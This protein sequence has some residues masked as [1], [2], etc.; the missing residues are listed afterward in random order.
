MDGISNSGASSRRVSTSKSV[1]AVQCL[2]FTLVPY[3]LK[4]LFTRY[5]DRT[6]DSNHRSHDCTLSSYSLLSTSQFLY[7]SSDKPFPTTYA[8]ANITIPPTENSNTT[9]SQL[10]HVIDTTLQN[11]PQASRCASTHTTTAAAAAYYS[12]KL[13]PGFEFCEY[14]S[15]NYRCGC[16]IQD[17]KTACGKKCPPV[18]TKASSPKRQCPNCLCRE[19]EA[20]AE[21]KAQFAAW[22]GFV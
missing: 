11:L 19:R 13:A 15:Y 12:S 18:A 6:C 8:S 10:D 17:Q 9:K 5:L 2:P 3:G 16:I 1:C 20:R 21:V 7:L 14:T 4:A 22:K